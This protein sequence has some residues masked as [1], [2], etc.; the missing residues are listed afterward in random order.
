MKKIAIGVE[1]EGIL[2]SQIHSINRGYYHHGKRIP[3][4]SGWTAERDGSINGSIF[5]NW[6]IPI[7]IISKPYRTEKGFKNAIENFI[8]FFSKD[9]NHELNQVFDFNN[10]CGCH[11]HFSISDFKF[12]NKVIYD[13]FKKLRIFFF[14]KIDNSNINNESKSKIK[15]HYDRN[16]ARV[17][18]K[19][20]FYS[21]DRQKEFNFESE[22]EGKGLEW[23]SINLYGIKSWKEFREVFNIILESL[24]FLEKNGTNYQKRGW[25]KVEVPTENYQTQKQ[26]NLEVEIPRNEQIN[27]EVEIPR[28][29]Q[30]NLEVEQCAI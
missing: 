10:S 11:I 1:I 8:N 19:N 18:Q 20:N 24:N 27:L 9:G 12:Y 5:N 16:Y 30:I 14:K 26:I 4:L 25:Y 28:N 13:I 23:R 15:N 21:S 3:G 22:R 6:S 7:E 17:V 29:E 2:N